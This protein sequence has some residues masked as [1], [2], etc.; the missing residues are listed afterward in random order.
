MDVGENFLQQFQSEE[1][2][3]KP[4]ECKL[5]Q[6][7]LKHLDYVV[8]KKSAAADPDKIAAV[9]EWGKATGSLR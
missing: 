4:S 1:L 7:K 3:L 9:S 2:K 6:R 8:S 5:F